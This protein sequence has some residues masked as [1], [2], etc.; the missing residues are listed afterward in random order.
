MNRP[1]DTLWGRLGMTAVAVG[2]LLLLGALLL[3][4]AASQSIGP[5]AYIGLLLIVAGVIATVVAG[6]SGKKS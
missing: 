5:V 1:Q 3:Q 2:G 6:R 4:Y